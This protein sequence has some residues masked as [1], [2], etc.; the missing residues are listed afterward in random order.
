V[1]IA[2]RLLFTPLIVHHDLSTRRDIRTFLYKGYKDLGLKPDRDTQG[3]T[4]IHDRLHYNI[5]RF[6]YIRRFSDYKLDEIDRIQ[7]PKYKVLALISA[8]SYGMKFD[9]DA[10]NLA[11]EDST[12]TSSLM[13]TVW[14]H[15]NLTT[16][17]IAWGAFELATVDS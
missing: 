12:P 10:Q 5:L 2:Y 14:E 9:Y 7:D 15:S 4:K 1:Y 16:I 17:F 3:Y 11:M 6:S 8:Y 13:L